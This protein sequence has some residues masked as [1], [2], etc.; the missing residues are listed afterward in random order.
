MHWSVFSNSYEMTQD[1]EAGAEG[2]LPTLNHNGVS[3]SWWTISQHQLALM[4]QLESIQRLEG[5]SFLHPWVVGLCALH[6]F[7]LWS[8]VWW[9]SGPLDIAE[10]KVSSPPGHWPRLLELMESVVQQQRQNLKFPH[11]CPRW[12]PHWTIRIRLT[13][14]ILMQC[15][16]WHKRMEVKGNIVILLTTRVIQSSWLATIGN[17]SF[18]YKHFVI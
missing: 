11:T 10:L 18:I 12:I 5:H 8:Q 7:F 14:L 9:T 15:R 2:R 6:L 1:T 4:E 3:R 17:H 13:L 16:P